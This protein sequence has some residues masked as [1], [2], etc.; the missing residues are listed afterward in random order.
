MEE[1][2]YC[3]NSFNTAFD[4]AVDTCRPILA[5]PSA[6]AGTVGR[7]TGG[8]VYKDVATGAVLARSSFHWLYNNQAEAQAL[9]NPYPGVG[10]NTLK[11]MTWNNPDM[12]VYKNTK[13]T[14]RL[15][16]QLQFLVYNPLNRA[17]YGVPDAEVED[18]G[19]TF[20]N[21]TG[22][23]GSTFGVGNGERNVQLGGK[24]IF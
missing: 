17:Y 21:F 13:I 24:F 7:N 19:S 10:R 2:S 1:G 6:P 14:E 15:N 3:D 16:M 11:G 22:N 23:T 12:S 8:G 9:G 20:G 4:S 18:A 5:N